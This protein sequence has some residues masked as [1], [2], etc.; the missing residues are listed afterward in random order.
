MITPE[1]LIESTSHIFTQNQNSLLGGI[2]Y[3]L[4][5]DKTTSLYNNLKNAGLLHIAVFSGGNIAILTSI[6]FNLL[7]WLNKR[8]IYIVTCVVILLFLIFIKAEP[9]S[10]RAGIMAISANVGL[11]FGRQ[12]NSLYFLFFSCGIM[13]L[14]DHSIID[15]L[16]FQ[17]SFLAVLGIIIFGKTTPE[18]TFKKI[19]YNNILTSLSASVFTT[20]LIF[21]KFNQIAAYSLFTNI[22]VVPLITPIIILTFS[23][24]LLKQFMNIEINILSNSIQGLVSI[25]ILL[26]ESISRLPFF[27]ISI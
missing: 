10:I 25:I 16:S 26:S 13:Y 12:N 4:D 8:I 11:Y 21:F 7:S 19:I 17:L 3:G 2:V 18:Y 23:M 15:S 6:I 9:P 24:H 5:I 27:M 22:L 1:H 20:P 14:Y